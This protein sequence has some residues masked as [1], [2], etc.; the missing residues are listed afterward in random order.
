MA[1][2]TVLTVSGPE[3]NISFMAHKAELQ[4]SGNLDVTSSSS[5]P[6]D[7]FN[8]VFLHQPA[9]HILQR[10]LWIGLL[11]IYL[12]QNLSNNQAEMCES[13]MDCTFIKALK[14]RY[15]AGIRV[16]V[17]SLPKS[18]SLSVNCFSAIY[19]YIGHSKEIL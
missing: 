11:L 17:S 12:Q 6:R 14:G 16:R 9:N 4:S 15:L 8:W 5:Y 13:F 3:I 1:H 2:Y 10:E 18:V 7:H 19:I